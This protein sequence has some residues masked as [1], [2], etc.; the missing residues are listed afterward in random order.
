MFAD[1]HGLEA[2]GHLVSPFASAHGLNTSSVYSGLFPPCVDHGS[3]GEGLSVLDRA[4]TTARLFHNSAAA[5]AFDAFADRAKPDVVHQHG[6]A[7][8]LS[9]SVLERAHGRGIPTVLTLH[10][11][12][13]RC[14]SGDLSR[15]GA[16]VCL[17]ISCAG[18]RYDR[19]VRFH[20]VHGS[21]AA[22][23]IAAAEL[24]VARAL[25]RYER[26]VDMFL[27]PSAY[28][29][30]R[31]REVRLPAD[32]LRVMPNAIEPPGDVAPAPPGTTSWPSAD[33]WPSRA[34]DWWPISPVSCQGSTSS[35][36]GR[37]RAPGPLTTS[38]RAR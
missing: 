6:L 9:P 22:S 7:R 23:A 31:M 38:G 13:L 34:F 8:Q 36:P 24:L 11:Y 30:D 27:V 37:A 12:S 20:C 4:R 10:D 29:G 1:A 3:L 2:R 26:S 5:S 25:R 28:V 14:P 32:R 17:D 15:S 18:H 19:A 16:P 33:S 35:W 21:R